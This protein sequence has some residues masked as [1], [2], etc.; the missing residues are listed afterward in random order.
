MIGQL[1]ALIR[2]TAS[3]ASNRRTTKTDCRDAEKCGHRLSFFLLGK[4]LP[5]LNHLKFPATGFQVNI[6]INHIVALDI[7]DEI[8]SQVVAVQG[9]SLDFVRP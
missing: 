8:P 6:R 2:G 5:G 9:D 3:R 1:F 7:G 4:L